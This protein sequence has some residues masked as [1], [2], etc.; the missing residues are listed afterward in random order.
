MNEYMAGEF[1]S[2]AGSSTSA[3]NVL[4]K[5]ASDLQAKL[6]Q[7]EQALQDYKE[8]HQAVSLETNQNITVDSLKEL[9]AKVTQAKADRLK[10]ESDYAAVRQMDK[11][12]PV[13]FYQSGVSPIT[14][15]S[16]NRRER[17]QNKRQLSQI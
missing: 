7:S 2:Q 8:T 10:L 15:P 9:S 4:R 16:W 13:R 3:L 12:S 14:L 5:Q 17:W 6:S 11:L 1:L